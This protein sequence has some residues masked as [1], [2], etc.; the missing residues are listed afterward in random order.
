VACGEDIGFP[1]AAQVARLLRQSTGRK[2]EEV[3]LVTSA[4]PQ[5]LG[6]AAWLHF[7]RQGWGIENGLHQ[8]L[9]ISFNDDRCRVKSHSGIWMLGMFRRIAVSLFMEWRSNRPRPDHVTT[10]HFQSLLSEDHR[11]RAVRLVTTARPSVRT[12][13]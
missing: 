5:R 8:R 11:R 13:S 10:T 1:F 6:P 12:L 2:D 4:S 7:N 9:D 3:A